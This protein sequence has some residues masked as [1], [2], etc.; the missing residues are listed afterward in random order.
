[1]SRKWAIA[2]SAIDVD[3]SA[4]AFGAPAATRLTFDHAVAIPGATLAP[5]TYIFERFDTASRSDLV[6]VLSRDCTRVYVTQ[7]T[8][9]ERPES[10]TADGV[11]TFEAPV[12]GGPPAISAWYPRGETLGHRFVYPGK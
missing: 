10:Q 6:R 4:G 2:V 5:G 9:V 11:V 8:P 12:A 7:F 3:S 1:M